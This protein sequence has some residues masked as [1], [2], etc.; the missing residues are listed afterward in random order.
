MVFLDSKFWTEE[1]PVYRLMQ[2]LI[3]KERYNNLLLS[4]TDSVDEIVGIIE[5]FRMN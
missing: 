5:D 4:I 3:E 2:H 1:M